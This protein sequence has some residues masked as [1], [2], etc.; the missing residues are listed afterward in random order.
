M[1][2]IFSKYPIGSRIT[3]E[4]DSFT[5][6]GYEIY[7]KAQYLICTECGCTHRR[8]INVERMNNN[9]DIELYNNN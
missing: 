3:L 1:N 4:G 7:E 6:T 5:V 9:G 8:L 2:K